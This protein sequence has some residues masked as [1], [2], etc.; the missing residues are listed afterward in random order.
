MFLDISHLNDE[1][2]EEVCRI[3]ERPFCATHSNSRQVH[4]N[5]RNLTDVQMERLAAQGGVMGLNGCDLIVGCT[6]GGGCASPA[7]QACGA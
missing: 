7:L 4:F 5:Y 6:D 2:F 3:A 1:G